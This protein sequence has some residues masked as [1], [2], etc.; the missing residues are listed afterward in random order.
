MNAPIERRWLSVEEAAEHTGTD[1][2]WIMA[3]VRSGALKSVV[4]ANRRSATGPGKY[5]RK[6]DVRDVDGL[7]ERLKVAAGPGPGQGPAAAPRPTR[8]A[9]ALGRE[10]TR[11]KVARRRGARG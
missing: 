8:P 3:H 10:S 2:D 5:R 6:L 11:E 1:V 9:A 7:M 4:T